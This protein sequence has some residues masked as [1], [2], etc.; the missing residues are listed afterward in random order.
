[1]KKLLALSLVL[2]T[3]SAWAE[4][5]DIHDAGSQQIASIITPSLSSSQGH[6]FAMSSGTNLPGVETGGFRLWV[7][8][9]RL[10]HYDVVYYEDA[11]CP[12]LGTRYFRVPHSPDPASLVTA[13]GRRAA[14]GVREWSLLANPPTTAPTVRA[15]VY[16]RSYCFNITPQALPGPLSEWRQNGQAVH[17]YVA[18]FRPQ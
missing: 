12:A 3:F 15:I 1:M 11:D 17:F 8:A 9:N 13:E 7:D 2:A 18:P 10:W 5:P 16:P 4:F 14:D 6:A